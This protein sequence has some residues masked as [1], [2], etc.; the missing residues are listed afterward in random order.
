MLS[1]ILQRDQA[2]VYAKPIVNGT[3]ELELSPE[4]REAVRMAEENATR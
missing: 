1:A 4:E 2:R 3:S